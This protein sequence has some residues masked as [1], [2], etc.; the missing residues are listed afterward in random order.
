MLKNQKR[1]GFRRGDSGDSPLGS[2]DRTAVPA[3]G[4]AVITA[5][6]TSVFSQ[7]SRVSST[8]VR[9]PA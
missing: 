8:S 7:G 9:L 6:I 4:S 2:R 3:R 1:S 5:A